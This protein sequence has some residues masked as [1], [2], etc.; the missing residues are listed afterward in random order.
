MAS[1]SGDNDELINIVC[2]SPNQLEAETSDNEILISTADI[3]SWDFPAILSHG[4]I[5]ACGKLFLFP[6]SAQWKFL[7]ALYFGIRMLLE[8][9]RT[10]FSE[11]APSKVPPE[12]DL[13][14]L[15]GI[16]NFS[17][18]HAYDALPEL[19][20]IYLA[21]TFWL[22]LDL[23]DMVGFEMGIGLV[24][25]S[26][27]DHI[28]SFNTAWATSSEL[29]VNLPYHLLRSSVMQPYLT[30]ESEM[31]LSVALFSWFDA[32]VHLE[33]LSATENDY[34]S[35]LK[36]IHVSLLPLW[37]AAGKRNSRFSKFA[38]ASIH[39]IF[40]LLEVPSTGSINVLGDGDL[41]GFRIRLTEFSKKVNLSSCSQITSAILLLSV[42]PSV[43]STNPTLRNT[44]TE[45][46]FNLEHFDRNHSPLSQKFFPTMS[47][48]AV[49]EVDISKCQRLHVESAIECFSVSFPSLKTLKAA[50]LLNF[51][52]SF[53]HHLVRKCPMVC[54]VDLS[55]D[56]SPV[57]QLPHVSPSPAK[58]TNVWNYSSGGAVCMSN[59]PESNIT[60][61][62]LE[63][64]NEL[65]DVELMYVAK[66][67]VSLQYLNIKGCVSLTDVG[68]ARLLYRCIRLESIVAC[69]T[70]FG[71]NS[72]QALCSNIDYGNTHPKL[73]DSVA[74]NLRTLHIGGC[75]G[76][77]EIFLLKLLSKM[78]L[79]KSLC[80]RDTCVV[81]RA[82]YSFTGSSLE[83]LDV[84]NTMVTGV[85]LA[86]IVC[87]NP[88]LTCLRVR[89]CRN[90]S[91]QGRN[92]ERGEI[93]SAYS[94]RDL[95]VGLSKT[96]RLEEISFGWGFSYFSIKALKPAI[97]SLRAIAVGL[98]A[99]LGEDI[100]IQLPSTCPI[101]ESI[102]LYFQEISD[103]VIESIVTTL[104]N[105]QVLVLCYCLGDMSIS[106]FMFSMP[107]LR[108]LQLERVTP[109]LTNDELVIMTQSCPNLIELSLLGCK[110]LNS[111]SQQIISRGWPGLISIHLEDCGEVTTN[112]IHSLLHCVALEDLLLRHNGAGIPKNF[113]QTA[114]S[115]MPLLR[116]VALDLCDARDD[117]FD[118]PRCNDRNYVSIV[119]IASCMSWGDGSS[120]PLLNNNRRP[121]H[122]ET[123]VVVWNGRRM[124]STVIEERV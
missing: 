90:L 118:I 101:L 26:I 12:I 106:G 113:I 95:E 7:S 85:V 10:W 38:D 58:V 84:S 105:L 64:R 40:T 97:T 100:L 61:L 69:G 123:H 54:E 109:W 77:D 13:D 94:Y 83:M 71:T 93:S 75:K 19:C 98:G 92:T 25:G 60:K 16:W 51:D 47:F 17:F 65:R 41:C 56:I 76:V 120:Y 63:G 82:L 1:S 4:T 116:K 68:I 32:N 121:M 39:S 124:A 20:A 33:E 11:E 87:K 5:K 81:D 50:Y 59:Q 46:P 55:T 3:L 28:M 37:Y 6:W 70:A 86:Y 43:Y 9:C 23:L 48:E 122:K 72:V 14:N 24:C 30:I 44:I 21:K 2:T 52:I 8:K 112:G 53:L 67:C 107:N 117:T 35:I 18:D 22:I 108:K 62:T 57:E 99:S 45:L 15:I 74:S 110:H 119:K 88:A 31:H 80:L 29:F 27:T 73:W 114:A 103:S 115:R 36:Q 96:C 78:H 34:T 79:L 104:R 91:Q 111:D 42:L 66:F 49:Q 102:V 89:D